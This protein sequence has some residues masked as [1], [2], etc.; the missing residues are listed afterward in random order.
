[1]EWIFFVGAVI[2]YLYKAYQQE[3]EKNVNKQRPPV[4][5]PG[6]P[7]PKRMAQPTGQAAPPPKKAPM[8]LEDLLEEFKEAANREGSGGEYAPER[9]VLDTPVPAKEVVRSIEYD[10][11]VLRRYE[12]IDKIPVEE[13]ASAFADVKPVKDHVEKPRTPKK[14]LIN[15]KNLSPK[16]LVV[17]SLILEKSIK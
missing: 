1:M 17:A 3:V 11:A 8:T 6:A 5:K 13:G 16:D 7:A 12:S 4:N 2:Y 10:D 9:Q 14:L 15:G